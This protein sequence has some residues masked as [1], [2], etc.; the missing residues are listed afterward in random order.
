MM[1]LSRP[2]KKERLTMRIIYLSYGRRG[3]PPP[4]SPQTPVTVYLVAFE[5]ILEEEYKIY[6]KGEGGQKRRE[7]RKREA[8]SMLLGY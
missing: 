8:F 5:S 2:L 6:K 4:L 7:E 3:N 1:A